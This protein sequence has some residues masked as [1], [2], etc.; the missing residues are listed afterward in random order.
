MEQPVVQWLLPRR[1]VRVGSGLAA[2][3]A[4]ETGPRHPLAG[5]A[6]VAPAQRVDCDEV[7]FALL[8]P[9]PPL[10]V[11]HLV[12]AGRQETAPRRPSTEFYPSWA[13]WIARCMEP[14]HAD[15]GNAVDDPND[16]V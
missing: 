5:V 3:L 15:Y 7:L 9:H 2:E 14:D 4:H 1:A 13:D 8:A 16:R 11:I 12:W 6:A 10:V